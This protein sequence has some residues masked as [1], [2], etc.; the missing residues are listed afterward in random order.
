MTSSSVGGTGG[1]AGC[2]PCA[3]P[4]G[5]GGGSMITS[6]IEASPPSL[7]MMGFSPPASPV[8][9]VNSGGSGAE[10]SG[11]TN[12]ADCRRAA[13]SACRLAAT[14]ASASCSFFWAEASAFSASAFSRRAT[15]RDEA[16]AKANRFRKEV[17]KPPLVSA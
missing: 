6:G 9:P 2:L 16:A 17:K 5:G 3:L 7:S 1:S 15:K 4:D 10:F 14:A 8:C 11:V 12:N 13:S